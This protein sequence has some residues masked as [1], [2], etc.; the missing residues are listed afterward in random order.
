MQVWARRPS[1][2][3]LDKNKSQDA[4]EQ[5]I[6]GCLRVLSIDKCNGNENTSQVDYIYLL[7]AI[8]CCEPNGNVTV[9]GVRVSPWRLRNPCR[10]LISALC[11]LVALFKVPTTSGVLDSK[12]THLHSLSACSGFWRHA[13]PTPGQSDSGQGLRSSQRVFP[14]KGG[15]YCHSDFSGLR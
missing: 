10:A 2:G 6:C 12:L 14:R 15:A 3:G 9:T 8:F 13:R 11:D 1:K 5:A 4:G 7:T